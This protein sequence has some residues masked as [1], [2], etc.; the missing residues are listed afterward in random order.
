MGNHASG[1]ATAQRSSP[2][3]RV[4]RWV[5]GTVVV[6]WGLSILTGGICVMDTPTFR[7]R[8]IGPVA[9]VDISP[10]YNMDKIDVPMLYH[11]HGFRRPYHLTMSVENK[12]KDFDR[13]EIDE[14]TLVLENGETLQGM[15]GIAKD[16]GEADWHLSAFHG[17]VA[18][19]HFSV[20]LDVGPPQAAPFS[21]KWKGRLRTK[22]GAVIP[23]NE[24]A[25]YEV[26]PSFYVLPY[27]LVWSGRFFV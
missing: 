11:Y 5:I 10:S 21:M 1:S 12:D 27:W 20:P 15:Q 8:R 13:I 2:S 16:I 7:E 23:F 18:V 4:W 19:Y 25:T 14:V 24:S 22:G 26:N 17:H 9:P 6:F 3:R